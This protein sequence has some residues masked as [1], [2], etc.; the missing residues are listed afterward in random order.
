G[1]APVNSDGSVSYTP[2][3]NFHGV[4]RFV[5]RVVNGEIASGDVTVT[6]IVTPVNDPPVAANDIYKVLEDIVLNVTDPGILLNDEDF[7]N[8]PLTA[9]LDEPPLH[10]TLSLDPTGSFQYVPDKNYHG[11]DQFV[12]HAND[13]HADSEPTTVTL[14]VLTLSDPPVPANDEYDV[15]EDGELVVAAPGVF[16]NDTNVDGF[17]LIAIRAASPEHG[18]LTLKSD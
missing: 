4:D 3:P 8:D 12:Y 9:V 13:G 11:T 2:E 14:Y 15:P 1:R 18:T 6:V 10:G 17:Q 7:D 16:A 5:Y